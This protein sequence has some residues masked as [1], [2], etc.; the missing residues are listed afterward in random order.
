MTTGTVQIAEVYSIEE[1]EKYSN[2]SRTCEYSD[3]CIVY[4]ADGTE[5]NKKGNGPLKKENSRSKKK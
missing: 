3:E 5:A 1:A 4:I 2:L